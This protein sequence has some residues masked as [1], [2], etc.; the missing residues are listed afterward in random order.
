MW[1]GS[2]DRWVKLGKEK[3][4]LICLE[5]I[6]RLEPLN[7]RNWEKRKE[8]LKVSQTE[9]C[10]EENSIEFP[11]NKIF[12][13]FAE[14]EDHSDVYLYLMGFFPDFEMTNITKLP[15][16]VVFRRKDEGSGKGSY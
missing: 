2:F 9:N 12:S 5:E 14:D 4:A 7:Q 16:F 1:K 11:A 15:G 10:R 8:F 6:I 3:E 13:G